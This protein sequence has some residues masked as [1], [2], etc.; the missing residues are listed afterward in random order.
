M[1]TILEYLITDYF[2]EN[3]MKK[4]FDIW[5]RGK[6]ITII[7]SGASFNQ[8][9][10]FIIQHEI[11]G[12][13]ANNDWKIVESLIVDLR[14]YIHLQEYIKNRVRVNRDIFLQLH[15]VFERLILLF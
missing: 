8:K 11:F 13:E 15:S 9:L 12:N 10:L 2:I 7:P 6:K 3:N 1:G 4:K 14:N 5:I